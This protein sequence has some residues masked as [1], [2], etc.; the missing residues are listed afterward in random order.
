MVGVHKKSVR[1]W[2]GGNGGGNSNEES[3]DISNKDDG[4][5]V[6]DGVLSRDGGKSSPLLKVE[7]LIGIGEVTVSLVVGAGT[8]DDPTEH[9]VTAIPDFGLDGRS[10]SPHS[11][12]GVFL[13]PVLYGI[14]EDSASDGSDG[15]LK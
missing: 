7:R 14:V 5:L 9:G 11:E 10:P 6:A 4:T 1:E 12:L 13:S 3:V 15:P 8:H 2:K